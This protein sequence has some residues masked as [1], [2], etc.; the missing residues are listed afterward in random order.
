VE[1]KWSDDLDTGIKAI[2]EQHKEL[3]RRINSLLAACQ[4]DKARD[5]VD[6]V[7]KFLEDYIVIHF[8]AEENIQLH[9]SYPGYPL[10]K[11]MHESFIMDIEGL[12]KQFDEEGS[13]ASM[14]ERTNKVA[15]E[16]LL[17]HI[18]RMDKELADYLRYKGYTAS[19]KGQQ[20]DHA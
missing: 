12:K 20:G 5:A 14:I 17:N 2:D 4:E 9:Y 10:H 3:F 18:K 16:W 19:R 8:I 6:D 13:S 11:A 1:I 7:L 15:I